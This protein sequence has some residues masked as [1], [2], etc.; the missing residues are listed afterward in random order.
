M[1]H[2]IQVVL[3]RI[4][5]KKAGYVQAGRRVICDCE[6]HENSIIEV[7]IHGTRF[8]VRLPELYQVMAGIR[9]GRIEPIR[10]SGAAHL[11]GTA[12][13]VFSSLSGRAVNIEL[14]NGDQFTVSVRSLRYVISHYGRYAP[15]YSISRKDRSV[16]HTV[17]S[18]DNDSGKG[19]VLC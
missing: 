16:M 4:M 9:S 10:N 3:G 18:L 17:C 11:C 1:Y 2:Y 8:G 12:G 6:G 14:N 5:L 13:V 15:L 19:S 7:V